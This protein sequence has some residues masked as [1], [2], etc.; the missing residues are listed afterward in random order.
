MEINGNLTTK[1]SSDALAMA[2]VATVV[3]WQ[4]CVS[5]YD[6]HRE[7]SLAE[8]GTSPWAWLMDPRRREQFYWRRGFRGVL[9]WSGLLALLDLELP[10]AFLHGQLLAGLGLIAGVTGVAYGYTA[11]RKGTGEG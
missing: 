6:R 8:D 1:Q 2:L 10:G 11:R 9:V 4:L 7:G 5:S 3:G